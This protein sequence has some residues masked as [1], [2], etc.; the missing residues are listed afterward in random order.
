M[1]MSL[2]RLKMV[3]FFLPIV[4]LWGSV[5]LLSLEAYAVGAYLLKSR[6]VQYSCN[7]NLRG[8]R[9]AFRG[10]LWADPWREYLPYAS[11]AYAEEGK[12]YQVS[13]NGR[14]FR[15]ADLFSTDRSDPLVIACLGGST[16]VEGDTDES[17]YPAYL[18][19]SLRQ[20]GV[21]VSVLNCG[22]SS[23]KSGGYGRVINHL[24]TQV[25]PDLVIEYNAVNDIC[26]DL[27][28]VWRG[29]L[30]LI[31]QLLLKSRFVS[32]YF[33]DSFIP[34]DETIRADIDRHIVANLVTTAKTLSR[35]GSR[36]TVASFVYPD[37]ASM[38]S[39]QYAQFDNNLRYWWNCEN[40]S[41]RRYCHIVDI[42][43]ERLRKTFAGSG[44]I[45]LPLAESGNYPA[46][47]FH[48]ICHMNDKGIR[49]KSE[50][51][52]LL[53]IPQLTKMKP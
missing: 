14:G 17:T 53:L 41:Y 27:F 47:Y 1:D 51:L 9:E 19:R 22:I 31:P 33:G 48:D 39:S 52:S 26:R 46:D 2:Y 30:G 28:T 12:S 37:P 18:Q 43:N 21:R 7:W 32:T 45:L 24:V 44:T 10:E 23:L 50:R 25:H 16:T 29:R 8:V 38:S 34:D 49:E 11:A 6:E 4:A 15:G 36:F 13:I 20:K 3:L 35:Y 40:L 5:L 42:Y